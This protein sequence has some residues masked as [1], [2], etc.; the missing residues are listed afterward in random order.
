MSK[1]FSF[2]RRAMLLAGL[3]AAVSLTACDKAGKPA[4]IGTTPAAKFN[5]V[6]ITGA[7]YARKLALT[8]FDGK[9]RQLSDFKGKVVFVFFGFTQCPD[10]CP[11]TMAELAEVRKRLGADGERLQGVFVT[12]DPERDTAEVLKAYLQSM[13]ASFVGLRG[14]LAETE[15]VASEFKVFYQK[16]PTKSGGYT[17]DHTAGAFVFDTDGQV[18]LFSRYG[19]KV[20]DLTADIKQ[21]LASAKR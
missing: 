16:V 5:S 12:V 19:S 18:R 4:A 11:T 1:L 9:P 7:K 8:D 21:L 15:A 14:S 20:D 10:V 2:S 13:D 3:A 17:M 6:D